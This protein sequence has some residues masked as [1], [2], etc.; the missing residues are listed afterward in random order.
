MA[1]V[2]AVLGSLFWLPSSALLAEGSGA[3]VVTPKPG[4]QLSW[5]PREIVF[6]FPSEIAAGDLD[7]ELTDEDGYR[8][9]PAAPVELDGRTLRFPT[10]Q[11]P[12]GRYRVSWSGAFTGSSEFAVTVSGSGASL[13]PSGQ[14]GPTAIEDPQ[15]RGG[16]EFPYL[17][18]VPVVL[19]A[20]LLVV[21]FR[22]NRRLA[23]VLAVVTLSC[24]ALGY[25]S[26]GGGSAPSD[27]RLRCLGRGGE[28]RL[29]CLASVVVDAYDD[30]GVS[31]ATA[32]LHALE[33]DRR[34]ASTYGENLCHSVAH[35]SARVVVAREGSL[36]RV[37]SEADLLCA[38]GFLHGALEGGAPLLES[39]V[40]SREVLG[41]CGDATDNTALECAHG[42]GHAASLRFNSRLLESADLCI[43]LANEAQVVQ[44]LLGAAM[45]S[46]NWIGNMAARDS[47][48]ESFTPPG[49]PTGSVAEPC[50]DERFAAFPDRFRAC[51]EGVFFYLKSGGEVTGRL[52]SPWNSV[53]GIAGWCVGVVESRP[54]LEAAC[55]SGLGSASA[56]R[57]DFPPAEMPDVCRR[58]PGEAGLVSCVESLVTQVRNNQDVSP[59]R[60]V[61]TQICARVPEQVRERC[62]AVSERLINR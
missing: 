36:T 44:C 52:P 2:F 6:S 38:S 17:L 40:F 22:R 45:L 29:A 23:G 26:L 12:D 18:L 54:S 16:E 5:S 42:I 30:G 53:D 51:L 48:P 60:E 31:A 24:S 19:G 32:E 11:L 7:V 49:V 28:E 15:E 13:G 59:P 20:L 9:P 46:G 14:T 62:T 4:D 10:P 39:A 37:A 56:L 34:F 1:A 47:A 3:V 35:M 27:A 50:L 58:A 61:F 25:V 57:L 55:F 8:Y 41:I 43:A 33:Q 21:L